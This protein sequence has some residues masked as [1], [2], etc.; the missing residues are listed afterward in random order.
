[1][2]PRGDVNGESPMAL[3]AVKV[4]RDD[5]HKASPR[6]SESKFADGPSETPL[7]KD[8]LGFWKTRCSSLVPCHLLS[9]N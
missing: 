9:V 6:V 2:C 5:D 8:A 7:S 1:M 4:E 3:V